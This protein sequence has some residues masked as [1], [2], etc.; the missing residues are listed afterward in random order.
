M[1]ITFN[2]HLSEVEPLTSNIPQSVLRR[3]GH[4]VPV[5]KR[6]K[7]S[8]SL[9][10]AKNI[11]VGVKD[12]SNKVVTNK[13]RFHSYY[14]DRMVFQKEVKNNIWGYSNEEHLTAKSI[15]M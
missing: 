7:K 13:F 4:A 5:N 14:S 12:G 1:L 2:R 3:S 9:S 6:K 8:H 15:C 10:I 11:K